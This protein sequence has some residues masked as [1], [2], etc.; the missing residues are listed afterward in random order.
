MAQQSNLPS[1]VDI[2]QIRRI[3]QSDVGQKLF[4]ALQQNNSAQIQQAIEQASVGNMDAAQKTVS[5][6]LS[7]QQIK[8]II[9]QLRGS[10]HG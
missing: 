10:E 9:E 2:E 3:A 4:A 6:L 1:G 8:S 5:Q 7:Q